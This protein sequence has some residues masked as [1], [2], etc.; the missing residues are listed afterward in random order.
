MN[1]FMFWWFKHSI[2]SCIFNVLSDHKP[3]LLWSHVADIYAVSLKRGV[4]VV[5]HTTKGGSGKFATTTL[6]FL[7]ADEYSKCSAKLSLQ[8]GTFESSRWQRSEDSLPIDQTCKCI[9]TITEDCINCSLYIYIYYIFIST[10]YLYL[11]YI[12]I[13]YIFISTINCSLYIWI[14]V[15]S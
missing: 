13:Y 2:L 5:G 7:R 6:I 14:L 10:I 3:G 9:K 4:Q 8:M 15:Y 1:Y 11:L 12:Y